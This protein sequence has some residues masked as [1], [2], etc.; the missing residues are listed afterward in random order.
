LPTTQT[1][2]S[3]HCTLKR[4]IDVER[5][6]RQFDTEERPSEPF[7]NRRRIIVKK[8]A[9]VESMMAHERTLEAAT[10]PAANVCYWRNLI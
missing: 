10:P 5:G 9:P 6:C 8:R 7:Q 3:S 4:F 1:S 2:H